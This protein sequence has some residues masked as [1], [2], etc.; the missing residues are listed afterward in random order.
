MDDAVENTP[1]SFLVFGKSAQAEK[2]SYYKS[3]IDSKI[4]EY[5]EYSL[6][7]AE[8]YFTYCYSVVNS[9]KRS[10]IADLEQTLK[11][12]DSKE[13]LEQA[14]QESRRIKANLIEM[15]NQFIG[16]RWIKFE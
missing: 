7:R 11:Q 5:R 16:L 15:K 4:S 9:Y 12:L 8:S 14:L 2:Q 3:Q 10:A 6:R 13:K 1:R